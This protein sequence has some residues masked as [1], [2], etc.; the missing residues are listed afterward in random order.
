MENKVT[1]RE[2][3]LLKDLYDA[4]KCFVILDSL[5][6]EKRAWQIEMKR[7]IFITSANTHGKNWFVFLNIFKS[8]YLQVY[9]KTSFRFIK[10]NETIN[11]LLNVIL[12]TGHYF[13]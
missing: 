2:C 8:I 1:K 9:L 13:S 7:A 12:Q 3:G 4:N 10:K 11:I 5:K 6:L